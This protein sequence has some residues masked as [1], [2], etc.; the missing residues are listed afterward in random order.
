MLKMKKENEISFSKQQMEE[1]KSD[2]K[3]CEDDEMVN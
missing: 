3:L 2:E 1:E